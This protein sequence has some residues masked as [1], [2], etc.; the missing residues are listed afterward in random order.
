MNGSFSIMSAVV[1]LLIN[2]I[3]EH[4]LLDS[5]LSVEN[6]SCPSIKMYFIYTRH[7]S[8]C[9]QVFAQS[10]IEVA[11]PVLYALIAT[12]LFIIVGLRDFANVASMND[13]LAKAFIDIATVT[14]IAADLITESMDIDFV[15]KI[16]SIFVALVQLLVFKT[17]IVTSIQNC[18]GYHHVPIFL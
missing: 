18:N 10:I 8:H 16:A 13:L 12:R 9:L 17:L 5:Y 6:Y 4:F 1:A 7:H 11:Q 14:A 3:C 2:S 15:T